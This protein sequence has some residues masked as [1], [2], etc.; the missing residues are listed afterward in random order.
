MEFHKITAFNNYI[1]IMTNNS[2]KIRILRVGAF[3]SVAYFGCSSE[4]HVVL[5]HFQNLENPI[6]T[7]LKEKLHIP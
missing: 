3:V 7:I 2:D 1:I 4:F 6:L 5:K